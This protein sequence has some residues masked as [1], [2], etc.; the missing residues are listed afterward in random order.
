M[1]D[2]DE[3]DEFMY[4]TPVRDLHPYNLECA[5]TAFSNII[6]GWFNEDGEEFPEDRLRAVIN[7]QFRN[8]VASYPD[9]SCMHILCRIID[10][11][12]KVSYDEHGNQ[13]RHIDQQLQVRHLKKCLRQSEGFG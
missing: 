9:E 8:K 11:S 1:N 3:L 7:T 13:K 6:V 12:K 4:Q 5:V 2:K 10:D